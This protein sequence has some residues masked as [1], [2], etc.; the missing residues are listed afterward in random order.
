MN[1][2]KLS[3]SAPVLVSIAALLISSIFSIA[4]LKQA[5]IAEQRESREQPLTYTLEQISTHY[6][7]QIQYEGTAFACP[8]PSLRL[9]VETGAL[10]SITVILF[11]GTHYQEIAELPAKR[12]W[13]GCYVE[14]TTPAP[15]KPLVENNSLYEYFFL[16]LEPMSGR[17]VIDMVCNS[18][19]MDSQDVAS[20]I[21]H[22]TS[23]LKADT[24]E[25]SAERTMLLAYR[26]LYAAIDDL[27]LLDTQM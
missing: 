27:P 10:R 26:A 9:K 8:A 18:I 17:P 25:A 1:K 7:Y 21:F 3:L 22:R 14:L 19:N 13:D 4:Q 15:Q 6:T 2:K 12:D 5:V 20:K 23:L 24:L 11:D 16:Y